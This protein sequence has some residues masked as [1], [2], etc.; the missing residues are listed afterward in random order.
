[1]PPKLFQSA[2]ALDVTGLSRHQLREWTGLGRRALVPADVPAAGPG[3]HALFTWQ[4]LLV[5]RLLRVMHADYGAE[6]SAWAPASKLLRGQL[7]HA[8]FPSLWRTKVVFESLTL[9]YL[10]DELPKHLDHAFVFSLAPHLN[11]LAAKMSVPQQDQLSLFA[12]MVVQR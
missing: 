10:T 6:V 5:L 9:V 3:R 1:M 7:E 4:T 8:I 2:D 12:P 11:A